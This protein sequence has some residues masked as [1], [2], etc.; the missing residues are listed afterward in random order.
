MT[1]ADVMMCHCRTRRMISGMT[2]RTANVAAAKVAMMK[3]MLTGSSPSC[4][5]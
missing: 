2:S 5:L 1:S 3:P 4:A